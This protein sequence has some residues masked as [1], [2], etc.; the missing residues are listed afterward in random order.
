MKQWNFVH[1]FTGQEAAM[2][3]VGLDPLHGNTN[4]SK[5]VLA[6]MNQDYSR[7][8][9][10]LLQV[11]SGYD[12]EDD[13]PETNDPELE[14]FENYSPDALV[15]VKMHKGAT[16]CFNHTIEVPFLD[17]LQSSD[18]DFVNQTFSR[19]GL[20]RWL[21]V[22]GLTSAYE[23]LPKENLTVQAA[24]DAVDESIATPDSAS[25]IKVPVV[26]AVLSG[27]TKE[28]R[29][30]LLASFETE[31]K[32]GKRGAL[33]RLAKVEMI[34]RSNLGKALGKARV[35]RTEQ[36]RAGGDWTSQLVRDGKR[37]S[38]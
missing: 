7:A 27:A 15:S 24:R 18:S 21:R 3:I 6:R 33:Q 32:N 11:V 22:I 25:N 1:E 20:T 36:G 12:N 28:G 19:R 2:L 14:N 38:E 31:Q 23:F 13:R 8:C 4:E 30:R 10:H 29:A 37:T 17:W 34:D 26:T 5:R 9:D 16:L 35:E